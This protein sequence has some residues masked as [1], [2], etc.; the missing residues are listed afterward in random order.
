LKEVEAYATGDEKLME[1]SRKAAKKRNEQ[2]KKTGAKKTI[3][4]IIVNVVEIIGIIAGIFSLFASVILYISLILDD[5]NEFV[6][7]IHDW[8][9]LT[10]ILGLFLNFL[11]AVYYIVQRM[12]FYSPLIF[13]IL[14]VLSYF[15]DRGYFESYFRSFLE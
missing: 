3:L 10:M 13:L 5:H 9:N 15:V 4:Q 6:L 1:A 12:K 2:T 11:I 7:K 14:S 8:F